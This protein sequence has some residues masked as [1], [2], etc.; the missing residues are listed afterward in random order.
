MRRKL[1]MVHRSQNPWA[2]DGKHT[3]MRN[4]RSTC[5]LMAPHTL[6]EPQSKLTSAAEAA[7]R[8]SCYSRVEAR[9]SKGVEILRA[10]RR[11]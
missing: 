10:A 8:R 1:F 7:S 6:A 3:S 11:I 9:P 4:V 2:A 5:E